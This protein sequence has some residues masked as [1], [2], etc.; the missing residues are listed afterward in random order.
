M[1]WHK[2]MENEKLQQR[3]QELENKIRTLEANYENL[4]SQ[5]SFPSVI[6]SI[7]V[8]RGFLKY[9]DKIVTVNASGKEFFYLV[10]DFREN[11]AIISSEPLY[12]LKA[13]VVNSTDDTFTTISHGLQGGEQ[14]YFQSS[15]G[16]IPAPLLFGA[17]YYP[18]NITTNTFKVSSTFGGSPI[19]L[20]DTGSG[21]IYYSFE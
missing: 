7:L 6:E 2:N 14:L 21:I 19:D 15:D 20:T 11:R 5:S 10:T 13:T 18:V 12:N 8:S 4:I 3:I 16:Y 17:T 9:T 1:V